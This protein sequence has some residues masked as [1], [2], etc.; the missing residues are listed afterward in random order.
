MLSVLPERL[1]KIKNKKWQRPISSAGVERSQPPLFSE[2]SGEMQSIPFVCIELCSLLQCT[3]HQSW[4]EGVTGREGSLLGFA[5]CR[6]PAQGAVT[7][8]CVYPP[9]SSQE[10]EGGPHVSAAYRALAPRAIIQSC[11]GSH[12]MAN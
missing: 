9:N 5:T 6:A 1:K 8:S 2:P 3:L 12:F 10:K 11:C 4:G 7:K